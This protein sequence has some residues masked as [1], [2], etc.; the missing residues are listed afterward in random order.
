MASF[1]PV[2]QR[3][4]CHPYKME[5]DGSNPSRATDLKVDNLVV[6]LASCPKDL[7]K[8]DWTF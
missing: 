2:T 4:E 3:L 8:G 6:Q 1:G 7:S 5:V